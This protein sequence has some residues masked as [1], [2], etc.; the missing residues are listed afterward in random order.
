MNSA[1]WIRRTHLFREGDYI[2][3]FCKASC[4]KPYKDCPVCGMIIKSAKYDPSRVDEAEGLSAI[5]DVD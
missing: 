4:I 1:H 3:S 2:C 5:L